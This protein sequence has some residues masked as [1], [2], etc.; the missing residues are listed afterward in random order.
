MITDIDQG[1]GDR[2][3]G[4]CSVLSDCQSDV[5]CDQDRKRDDQHSPPR[6]NHAPQ[7]PR[8]LYFVRDPYRPR[9]T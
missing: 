4:R 5:V 7:L 2:L 8:H 1:L 3:C 6:A 9:H